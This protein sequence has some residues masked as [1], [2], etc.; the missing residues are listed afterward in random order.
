MNTQYLVSNNGL[1]IAVGIIGNPQ[2]A[3]EDAILAENLYGYNHSDHLFDSLI[4]MPS[5]RSFKKFL[6]MKQYFLIYCDYLARDRSGEVVV[7]PSI[8][9]MTKWAINRAN[10]IMKESVVYENFM[11]NIHANNSSFNVGFHQDGEVDHE[12]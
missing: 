11:R 7:R 5:V 8:T 4:Y 9:A 3:Q 10:K 6:T 1:N 2:A 12:S